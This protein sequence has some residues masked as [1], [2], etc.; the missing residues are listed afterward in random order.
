MSSSPDCPP[1]YFCLHYHRP[2]AD[3][4]G[5]AVYAY[6]DVSEEI[7]DSFDAGQVFA[8][9][10]D[11]HGA[12]YQIKL[13]ANAWQIGFI[14]HN[15]TTGEKDPGPDMGV[16]LADGREAWVI[17]GDAHP[18]LER[19]S[20][21]QLMG[22]TSSRLQ[23]YWID[24]FTVAI[25]QRYFHSEWRY[26]LVSS[27]DG[28]LEVSADGVLERA[29]ADIELSN[30]APG[31]T[32]E[33]LTRFPQLS[34]YAVFQIAKEPSVAQLKE[35]LKGRL[36]VA[37]YEST[38]PLAYLTGVQQA[39]VLDDLFYYP[40]KLGTLFRANESSVRICLWA[41]TAQK[42]RVLLFKDQWDEAPEATVDMQENNGTWSA[43][44]DHSWCDK[45]YLFSVSVYVPSAQK[46]V[47]NVVTD[48]YS[49]DLALDGAKT[50]MTDL[51]DRRTKPDGWDASRSP[52][53]RAKNDLSVY[54]LHVREFSSND[55]S[56]T[57]LHRGT[58]LAFTDPAT[59]GM[60]HL[61]RLAQA[62]L[63]AVHLLPTYHFSSVNEDKTRWKFPGDL[64][65]FP[66]DSP[67]QQARVAAVQNE[68]AYNWGYDPVH[69]L[70]PSGAY[71][72]NPD[73]RVKEYRQMVLGLHQAGLRVIQD[74]VFNHTFASEQ[75]NGSILDKIVPGYY[76]RL[77]ADGNVTTA[78]CCPDTAS[79][80]RMME[81][82][83]IDTLV[84]N[85]REYKID[86][87]RFDLMGMHF[88]S[89][90]QHISEALAR[91]TL[92]RDGVDGSK[93]YLYGEGW[94]IGQTANNALGP[95]A[96]QANMYGTG[97]GTFNDR[98][99]DGVRGGGPCLRRSNPR[100]RHR[101]IYG[102]EP[103]HQRHPIGRGSTRRITS[104][105]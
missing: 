85:A 41:P 92:E 3:Y 9:G 16:S 31:L 17:S 75:G 96:S 103:I 24:R 86:G 32:A 93:I 42:V 76:Y 13:K 67:E 87:F 28:H 12:V 11:S 52:G 101:L 48:P 79:E 53:L 54:E 36:A 1:G 78:S 95:N 35:M 34:A 89:N 105:D 8:T 39:G 46:L 60:Q 10:L 37:A 40:G 33:Q 70:A 61:G 44:G 56:V 64:T 21:A 104:A 102:P 65:Q 57:E 81:K 51:R 25:P 91:L 80:R 62:G 58:Y 88:V 18:Y 30:Y 5:W 99:R 29:S 73:E 6:R 45:Y 49:V 82:L 72:F 23:A 94:Q 97:I 68:D 15:V 100:L 43:V 74:Q 19:P 7:P 50:R 26:L 90:M 47:E 22:T 84:Q 69:Y 59:N 2:D 66:P 55:E 77:D 20:L 63:R 4:K 14:V 71:A 27:Q 98:I 83:M 38:G